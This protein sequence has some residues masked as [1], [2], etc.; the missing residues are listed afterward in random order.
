MINLRTLIINC[1][2]S[3]DGLS[4]ICVRHRMY[5]RAPMHIDEKALPSTATCQKLY[6]HITALLI[7]N[8]PGPTH[9]AQQRNKPLPEPDAQNRMKMQR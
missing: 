8:T 9:P 3:S 7:V 5:L 6:S 2:L 4:T 1:L